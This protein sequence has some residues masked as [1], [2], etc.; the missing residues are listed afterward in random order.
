MYGLEPRMSDGQILIYI[1]IGL[2]V[3][4]FCIYLIYKFVNLCND[5][6]KILEL[7]QKRVA[8]KPKTD[9]LPVAKV[10]SIKPAEPPPEGEFEIVVCK[11]CGCDF[12]SWREKCPMCGSEQ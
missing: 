7:M 10:E 9:E 6:R 11:K 5:V 3:I 4:S 12:A 2:A 8:T 1:L